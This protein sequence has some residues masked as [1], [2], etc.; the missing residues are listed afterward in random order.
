MLLLNPVDCS[1]KRSPWNENQQGCLTEPILKNKLNA[2]K[3]IGKNP[4]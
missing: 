2:F 4:N 1:E 3:E